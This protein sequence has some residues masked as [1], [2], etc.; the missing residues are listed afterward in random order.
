MDNSKISVESL[1]YSNYIKYDKL[2]ELVET[3]FQGS[4]ANSVNIFIDVYSLIKPLYRLDL[5]NREHGLLMSS[6]IINLCAHLRQFFRNRYRVETMIYII[7][8]NNV[9]EYNKAIWLGYNQ[10]HEKIINRDAGVNELI[11]QNLNAVETLSPYLPDIFY[12]STDFESGVLIYDTICYNESQGNTNPNIIISK[13]DYLLQLVSLC[14]NLI[15]FRP[16][17]YKSEDISYAVNKSNLLEE[18]FKSKE[19]AIPDYLGDLDPG[20]CSL[21]MS[22]SR[23]PERSIKSFFNLP[24][25]SEIIYSGVSRHRILNGYNSNTQNVWNSLYCKEFDKYSYD[26]FDRRFKVVDILS[27]YLVYMSMNH[28]KNKFINLVSPDTV[29]E[30]NNQYYGKYPL[31]LNRL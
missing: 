31:D 27:Q 3:N 16:K 21:L 2:S 8:S 28:A 10:N 7:Q 11:Q 25:A 4:T 6:S 17:K 24:K 9:P 22:L 15:V 14:N 23:C 30:I 20:L 18:W 13:D 19:V 26:L 1:L 29:K 5:F 12:L